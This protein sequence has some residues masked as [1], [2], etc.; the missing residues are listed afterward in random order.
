MKKAYL[1]P[2]CKP[3]NFE[4]EDILTGSKDDS[5]SNENEKPSNGTEGWT[6]FF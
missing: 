3:Q 2:I 6:G 5:S 4:M 1:N